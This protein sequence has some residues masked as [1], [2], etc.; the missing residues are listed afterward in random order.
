MKVYQIDERQLRLLACEFAEQALT[1]RAPSVF[2][3]EHETLRN[4]IAVSRRFANGGLGSSEL[5]EAGRSAELLLSDMPAGSH[6]ADD[7]AV[8]A[9]AAACRP[10]ALDAF[11]VTAEQHRF[12]GGDA[13]DH[14]IAL[15]NAL[16]PEP[17]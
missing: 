9:C 5:A 10:D 13:V 15:Y 7:I 14:F 6:L 8:I 4:A 16:D 11:Q 3:R 17:S 2:I 12:I 1:Y